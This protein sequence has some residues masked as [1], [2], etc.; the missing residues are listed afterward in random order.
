MPASIESHRRGV[1]PGTHPLV[2]KTGVIANGAALSAAIAL[3]AKVPVALKMPAAWTANKVTF[4]GSKDGSTYVEVLLVNGGAFEIASADAAVN[5]QIPLDARQFAG[6]THVK[7]RS[8]TVGSPGNQGA[9][10]TMTLITR[11]LES[12]GSLSSGSNTDLGT[13]SVPFTAAYIDGT[14]KGYNIPLT[15]FKS[16][17]AW[18][19]ALGDAP[20]SS[21]LGLADAP[22]SPLLGNAANNTHPTDKAVALFTLPESYVAGSAVTVRIAA[23]LAGAVEVAGKVDLVAKKQGNGALG[24]DICA[25]AAQTVTGDDTYANFDFVVTPTTLSPGDVLALEVNCD[26]DDTAGTA[27]KAMSIGA[28]SVRISVPNIVAS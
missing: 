6:F 23:K 17:A 26:N 27:N 7:V 24:A 12:I 18:K 25:T 21:I 2:E 4:Q 16:P 19:D 8:G 14:V 3:G 10:R 13:A 11:D 20:G 5:A 15:E 22:G 28:V 1:V 9:A